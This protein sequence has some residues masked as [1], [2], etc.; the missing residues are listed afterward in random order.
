MASEPRFFVLEKD[1]HGP[2][3][4]DAEPGDGFETGDAPRCTKCNRYIGMCEWLPPFRVELA[5]YGKSLG[6]TGAVLIVE[7]AYQLQS[8]GIHFHRQPLLM[9]YLIIY[10]QNGYTA[11][12]ICVLSR[13]KALR[14]E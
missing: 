3:D 14:Q 1:F 9:Y 2:H 6:D 11:R 7:L 10:H 5:V 12:F 8:R 13:L 4:T